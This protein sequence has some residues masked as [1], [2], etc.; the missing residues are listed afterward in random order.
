[1]SNFILSC[2]S[3][4]D[5]SVEYFK[6]RD[7]HY[8]CFSFELGGQSYPD[9]MG[10][11]IPHSERYKRMLAGEEGKTSQIG[12]GEYTEYFE[13]FLKEG[14]DVLHLT[15]SSGIS[16]TLNSALIAKND[17]S[18][19]YPDRKLI[20][21]DSLAASSGY[22]LLM[23]I[24]A[25]QRD[26]GKSIDEV[27][28]FAMNHRLN[29][30]HWFFSSDLTFFIKGGRVSKAAGLIGT[31][32]GICPLLN[33]DYQG[34]L[35][36]REKVK[37]KKKVIKRIVEKMLENADNGAAYDGKCFIS[38]SECMGDAKAV[39]S[40]IEEKIPA[41]KGKIRIFDI[42]AVIGTHTGPGT[43]ALFFTGKERVD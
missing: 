16:G 27:A 35:I 3:T 17:L 41:M 8:I 36:P 37:S 1:M 14:K 2:C 13:S 7:I 24:L 19:K 18:E 39:A 43:V 38:Q 40:L 12:V 33:V 32:L 21:I 20:V 4:A 28:D 34:K 10:A 22:G 5:L 31:V 15:L 26:A 29:I 9:D 23:D 6:E 42:G 30:N 11:S 25:D